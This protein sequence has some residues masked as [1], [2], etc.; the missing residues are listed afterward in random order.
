VAKL[1]TASGD[2]QVGT[3]GEPVDV[4]TASGE[5]QIEAATAGGKVS[6]AS[7]RVNVHRTGKSIRVQS[8]S[9][10]VR[11]G[12]APE[13]ARVETVS[14]DVRIE[15]ASRGELIL[16][17]VSG[18]VAVAVAPGTLIRFD[19][20]SLSGKVSSEIQVETDRPEYVQGA[21]CS[22]GELLVQAKTVA[23]NIRVTRAAD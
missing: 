14:G 9:G 1:Q 6:V 3:V 13:G 19:A 16:R 20:G 18:E 8:A 2:I 15:R 21:P 23:G 5:V 11:I 10:D 12:E 4:Q 7:G 17:T 22:G